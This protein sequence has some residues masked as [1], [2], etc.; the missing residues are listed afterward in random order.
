[1][2]IPKITFTG[3]FLNNTVVP[4]FRSY[5]FKE[6]ALLS[7]GVTIA[8]WA[9]SYDVIIGAPVIIES[10]VTNESHFT[11]GIEE[12]LGQLI[13][14]FLTVT[15]NLG[16]T[17][18]SNLFIYD[19]GAGNLSITSMLVDTYVLPNGLT[20]FVPG[21]LQIPITGIVFLPGGF[22]TYEMDYTNDGIY[23]DSITEGNFEHQYT[24][25]DT[26]TARLSM[27]AP[28]FFAGALYI[29]STFDP[30]IEEPRDIIIEKNDDCTLLTVSSEST[31]YIEKLI[32]RAGIDNSSMK[33]LGLTLEQN[34]CNNLQ[35]LRLAPT[36]NFSISEVPFTKQATIEVVNINGFDYRVYTVSVQVDGLDSACI[37][38]VAYTAGYNS[39][40]TLTPLMGIGS[41]LMVNVQFLVEEPLVLGLTPV[42]VE[43]NQIVITTTEGF[44]YTINYTLTPDYVPLVPITLAVTSVD[45][46]A[47]PD[48]ISIVENV[49][50]TV[51]QISPD[52]YE[53]DAFVDGV[54]QATLNDSGI[55][56]TQITG[57][58]F[59]DCETY[60]LIIKALAN[61]CNPL[62]QV[63][64]DALVNF[65]NCRNIPCT[66]LCDLYAYLE[67]LL[68]E[69]D[70]AIYQNNII[71]KKNGCG[72]NS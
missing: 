57:C 26:V 3:E 22:D 19:D 34:C 42:I 52:L 36:Y 70:C 33:Y 38:S 56:N 62:I 28:G 53:W 27:T 46:P 32:G 61:G 8:S 9:W 18:S 31:D 71:S 59:V 49:N 47:Y 50:N 1:M 69:C 30:V 13:R 24:T 12:G 44:E 48:G 2:L 67:T 45:Y 14:V 64:Y 6:D 15:D 37:E 72:C 35:E 58:T 23:D 7:E 5:S 29:D 65:E 63:L 66:N 16:R 43:N 17:A 51:I 68:D 21:E 41:P 39:D 20:V 55:S 40:P 25:T 4:N 54:Y 60:C 11:I 10:G